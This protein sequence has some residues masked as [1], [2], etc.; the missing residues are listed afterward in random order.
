MSLPQTSMYQSAVLVIVALI[1]VRDFSQTIPRTGV[2]WVACPLKTPPIIQSTCTI[3]L[4]VDEL[5]MHDGYSM[6]IYI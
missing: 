4:V 6:I 3:M 2:A 1:I 5:V